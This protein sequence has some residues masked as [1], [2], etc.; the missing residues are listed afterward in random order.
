MGA[1][2]ASMGSIQNT[3]EMIRWLLNGIT[4]LLDVAPG[5]GALES[6]IIPDN[7]FTDNGGD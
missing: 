6:L 7:H 5:Y 1:A 4:S 2:G 3:K